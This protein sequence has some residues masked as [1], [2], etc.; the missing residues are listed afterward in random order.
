MSEATIRSAI[1]Q[2]Q[3][4]LP[5][6]LNLHRLSAASWVAILSDAGSI[7]IKL[8]T[9][10]DAYPGADI[11]I[12]F[13]NQPRMLLSSPE[14]LQ[15]DAALVG[16]RPLQQPCPCPCAC[17]TCCC[18]DISPPSASATI[19]TMRGSQ[20]P[21]ALKAELSRENSVCCVAPR[22][23]CSPS[24]CAAQLS[25]ISK[26]RRPP[27]GVGHGD[28]ITC[29]RLSSCPMS[30]RAP[31]AVTLHVS[32]SGWVETG[33]PGQSP[34]TSETSGAHARRRSQP[35][36]LAVVPSQSRPV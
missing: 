25:R 29:H 14:T 33:S 27:V 5:D 16:G 20:G 15:Q 28:S 17:S 30:Q 9:V 34:D 6:I 22:C 8:I 36:W 35:H 18:A 21:L 3:L 2:L 1:E 32:E 19:A 23:P 11:G 4:L 26:H 10:K 24:L 31:H 7:P 12:L 13:Q